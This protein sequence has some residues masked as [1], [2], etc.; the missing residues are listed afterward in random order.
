MDPSA[1][2]ALHQS[3]S[4]LKSPSPTPSRP[5]ITLDEYA[6]QMRMAAIM[7]AQLSASQQPS[8]SL[9]MTPSIAAGMVVG[10]AIALGAGF[11]GVVVGAGLAAVLS[12]RLVS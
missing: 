9:S 6:E 8:Q 10:G 7:L 2:A 1:L 4:S 12:R 3:P 11:V 5:P